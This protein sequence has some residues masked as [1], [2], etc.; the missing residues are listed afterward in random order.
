MSM[1][2]E[3]PQ[4]ISETEGAGLRRVAGRGQRRGPHALPDVLHRQAVPLG[5]CVVDRKQA[6]RADAEQLLRLIEACCRCRNGR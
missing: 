4:S 1:R 6:L 2:V 3:S 5:Q